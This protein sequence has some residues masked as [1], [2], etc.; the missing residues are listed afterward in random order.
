[1]IRAERQ[2]RQVL[3]RWLALLALL[4]NAS[5]VAAMECERVSSAGTKRDCTYVEEMHE[6]IDDA[7]DAKRDCNDDAANLDGL[8]EKAVAYSACQVVLMTNATACAVS[9]T[10][11]WG[12]GK[13]L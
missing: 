7:N 13:D 1:M 12:L 3:V 4:G 8:F 6:C 11:E 10:S 9:V 5:G 2:K